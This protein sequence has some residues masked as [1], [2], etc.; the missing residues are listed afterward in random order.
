M[1]QSTQLAGEIA[2]I[3][4]F[5]QKKVD[6]RQFLDLSLRTL[7]APRIETPHAEI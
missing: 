1:V 7:L 2:N 5:C 3:L 4:Y 6:G